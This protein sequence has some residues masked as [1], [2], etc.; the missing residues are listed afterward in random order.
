MVQMYGKT[1]MLDERHI[2]DAIAIN[3]LTHQ[4]MR[5]MQLLDNVAESF[6]LLKYATVYNA[7]R[8]HF[9]WGRMQHFAVSHTI[10]E[11]YSKTKGI[12]L[13]PSMHSLYS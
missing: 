11:V 7:T 2:I 3:R 6:F 13:M 5:H 9:V 10:S 8:F 12:P 1:I 4:Y